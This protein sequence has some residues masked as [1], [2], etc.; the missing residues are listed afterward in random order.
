MSVCRC[1]WSAEH[2]ADEFKRITPITH[3]EEE[4]IEAMF[5]T[6]LIVEVWDRRT[7][8]IYCT[9]CRE[10]SDFIKPHN[11]PELDYDPYN[12]FT[13]YYSLKHGD[14]TTCPF[15]GNAAEIVY[16]GKMGTRCEKMWQQVQVVVFHAEKD[17]WLS[18]QAVYAVKN[19]KGKEWDTQVDFRPRAQ[20]LFRP[21]CA[22][23]R[24]NEY[25]CVKRAWKRCW[26]ET[27]TVCE[28]FKPGQ[29]DYWTGRDSREYDEIGLFD[30]LKN[31]DMRYCAADMF[32][33]DKEND[34]G[35]MR[36]LGEYCH[37]PQLE[38]LTKLGLDDIR[39]EL[40]YCHRSNPRLVNWRA[41][42]LSGFLRLDK[43]YTKL[44]MQSKHRSIQELEVIQMLRKEKRYDPETTQYLAGLRIETIRQL[45]EAAGNRTI[46]EVVRYLRKQE[47]RARDAAQLWIDYHRMAIDLEYDLTEDTVFF[48]K[49]LQARHDAAAENV[50]LK[51][52]EI[53]MK[54]YK[55]RYKKLC[56]MYEFTDGEFAIVVPPTPDDII[57]EGKTLHH[58]VGSYVTRHVDGA[59]TILFLRKADNINQ[60]YGTI[61]MSVT[62][63]SGMIQLRGYRNNDIPRRESEQF[64]AEWRAWIKAGSPRDPQ[65]NP[66]TEIT[67]ETRVKVTA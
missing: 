2:T 26:T 1:N 10:Q 22:L 3:K 14:Q 20:Y 35:L 13:D 40:I 12:D 53:Q 41:A 47:S 42:D 17:G 57:K 59:T 5:R 62:D 56:R 27:T 15:C 67:I 28:P 44:F 8:S 66:I 7:K 55:R 4:Q 24:V 33:C 43:R 48:P 16:A 45:H 25:R 11:M 50:K 32:V 36:Y 23:Q 9:S 21:G 39:R 51:Q 6:Y 18:A 30:C 54:K 19:Y 37:R 52:S 60:P 46:T 64:I 58:C 29:N 38:M 61:E 49:D 34:F 65:G 31:T 63:V